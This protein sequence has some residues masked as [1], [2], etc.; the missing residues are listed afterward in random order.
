MRE[1]RYVTVM[2]NSYV[3]VGKHHYSAPKEY[4][5]KCVDIVFNADTLDIY[6]GLRL[7]TTHHRND[8]PYG[9]TRKEAHNLLP[10]P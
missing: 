2:R 10:P 9:Y 5:G 4:I 7:V 8:T 6:L 1:R 3:T